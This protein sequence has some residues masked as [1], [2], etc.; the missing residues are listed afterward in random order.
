MPADGTGPHRPCRNQ[1]RN[2][3]MRYLRTLRRPA[4]VLA[5]LAT[6]AAVAITV[7]AAGAV[8]AARA[9]GQPASPPPCSLTPPPHGNVKP[10][11]VTTIGQAYS[12]IFDHYY[13]ASTLDDRVLLAAAFAG[14]TQELDRLGLD[15]PGATLPALTGNHNS[16]WAAFAA[17]YQRITGALPAGDRQQAAAATMKAM[18][19]ALNNNHTSW[20]KP[21]F[22]RGCHHGWCS[23]PYGLGIRTSPGLDVLA[24]A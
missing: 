10:T 14:L 20:F 23:V 15:Q 17:V 21:V 13:A 4:A 9:S 8:G 11:T 2:T 7:T 1:R 22:W 19:A 12:C 6:T 24:Q 16:D 18:V 5:A 3:I